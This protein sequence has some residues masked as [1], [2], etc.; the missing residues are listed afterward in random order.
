MAGV[1]YVVVA[2]S[3]FA[4]VA[5]NFL[6]PCN[7]LIPLDR[8]T[9]SV[10]GALLCYLT[11]RFVFSSQSM[12]VLQAVDFDV[13]VL[14][15]SIM[16]IN[17]LVVHLKETK[18]LIEFL[19]ELVQKDP[20]RGFWIISFI[21]FIASPFLTNDGVCLLFVEPILNAFEDAPMASMAE[22]AV[23]AALGSGSS[24]TSKPKLRL[25]KEDAIYF[26]L[27]LACSAN[28]GSALTYTGNPQNM[29]VASDAI[30]VLP[31]YKFLLYMLP[32]SIFSW[33][34]TME[35][36][37]RC[38]MKSRASLEA[39]RD[40]VQRVIAA[41]VQAAAD[42]EGGEKGD[43]VLTIKNPD[44][45]FPDDE[46]TSPRRSIWS[47]SIF[48][49]TGAAAGASAGAASPTNAGAL[50]MS[51]RRKKAQLRAKSA[52]RMVRFISSPFPYLVL[53][54]LGLMVVMIFVDL[55]PISGLICVFAIL[56][57]VVVVMG[58]HWRNRQIWTEES[59]HPNR[60]PTH[61]RSRPTSTHHPL[62]STHPAHTSPLNPLL[63]QNLN[64]RGSRSGSRHS[65][66][67]SNA[68]NASA[69]SSASAAAQASDTAAEEEKSQY[70][71]EGIAMGGV[72][73]AR[74][75]VGEREDAGTE[76]H[77]AARSA[78]PEEDLG[79]LTSEDKLDNLNQFFEALFASIDY[80]LLIIFL[81]LF[82]VVENMASTGI[83]KNIW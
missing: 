64:V 24:D 77:Y 2:V 79:P 40:T 15:S 33:L 31:S 68:S 53:V 67:A 28:I 14:L 39:S 8:R 46:A 19:Q 56:M 71:G 13:M 80:S 30:G 26:L 34:V 82:I 6:F 47:L 65:R 38:W 81:G 20:S 70:E 22:G 43:G 25:H 66:S 21:A 78:N 17:H 83:P 59:V 76:V 69:R 48:G 23:V 18:E 36:I 7:Y 44:T 49:G 61:P 41:N 12:D 55:M 32:P 1:A 72:V 16:I 37:R 11:R 73:G 9:T 62:H 75:G 58:N 42:E 52:T 74:V 35:W 4:F 5:F 57:V 51:P 63:A 27:G 50:V 3:I 60:T 10:L 54:L 29:I 45:D